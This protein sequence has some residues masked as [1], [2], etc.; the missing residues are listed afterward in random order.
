MKKN[1]I[2][3]M[4][5]TEAKKIVYESASDEIDR[6]FNR[7]KKAAGNGDFEIIIW[8][9]KISEAAQQ[10]FIDLGFIADPIPYKESSVHFISWRHAKL[11]LQIFRLLC[12][13]T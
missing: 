2:P 6:L 11:S 4:D 7:I 5:A 1:T 8:D 10:Y 13:I 12:F 9:G 3:N